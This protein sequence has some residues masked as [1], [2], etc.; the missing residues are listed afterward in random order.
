MMNPIRIA[1]GVLLV[2]L[3]AGLVWSE[4][5]SAPPTKQTTAPATQADPSAASDSNAPRISGG[6]VHDAKLIHWVPPKL[7]QDARKAHIS[8]MVRLH[9]VIAKDGSVRLVEYVSGPEAL[10]QAAIDAVKQWQ[11]KPKTMAGNP[12]E[13]DETIEMVFSIGRE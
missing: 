6:K 2:S 4:E 8:G 13:A 5:Q 7:P 9:A 3:I 12:V 10:R 1:V 11:Y